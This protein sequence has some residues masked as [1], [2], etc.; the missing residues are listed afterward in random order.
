MS[1][2][3]NPQEIEITPEMVKVGVMAFRE[4]EDFGEPDARVLVRAMLSKV[5]GERAAFGS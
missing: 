3:S 4:W 2:S 1:D 5:L